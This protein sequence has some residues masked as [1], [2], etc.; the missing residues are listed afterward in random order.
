MGGLCQVPKIMYTISYAVNIALLIVII[1]I[2][3]TERLYEHICLLSKML[4]NL[5]SY[6][7]L[8][9]FI[10]VNPYYDQLSLVMIWRNEWFVPSAKNHVY[11][12]LCL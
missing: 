4:Q 7:L 11:Y 2:T 5:G 8:E 1:V 10:S 6:A 9:G 12:F 3:A